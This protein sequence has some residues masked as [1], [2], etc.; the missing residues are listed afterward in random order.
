MTF[1]ELVTQMQLQGAVKVVKWDNE[2]D[3]DVVYEKDDPDY[4]F[5]QNE[6]WADEEITYMFPIT[7]YINGR[8]AAQIVIEI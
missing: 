6:N 3:S 7:T 2:E 1:N 8:E 4:H 5:T